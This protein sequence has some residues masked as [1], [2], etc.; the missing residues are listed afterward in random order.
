MTEEQFHRLSS[1][2]NKLSSMGY[3]DHFKEAICVAL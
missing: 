1:I 2:S 3:P